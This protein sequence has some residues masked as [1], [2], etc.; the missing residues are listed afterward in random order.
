MI[1]G[2]GGMASE[3][4]ERFVTAQ[5]SCWDT[6]VEELR[7]GRK[8]SHYS[9]YAFPQCKGLGSSPMS[10][11]YAIQSREEAEAYLQHD[12][13]GPRL[14]QVA[15]LVVEANVR[16]LKKMLGFTDAG[17]FR[18]CMTL[19]LNIAQEG[20]EDRALFQKALEQCDN[21]SPDSYTLRFLNL[22]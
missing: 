4:L 8:R 2:L 7:S 14:R 20:S 5:D 13:L 12:I 9:W 15:T 1:R 10:Q 19:F 3:G 22:W 18:S 16:P 6:V 11:H 17:K 21:T